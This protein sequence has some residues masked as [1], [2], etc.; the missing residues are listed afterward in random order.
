M[1]K[2]NTDDLVVPVSVAHTLVAIFF[3]DSNKKD[4]NVDEIHAALFIAD[5]LKHRAEVSEDG[6]VRISDE[7]AVTI[8]RELYARLSDPY[9]LKKITDMLTTRG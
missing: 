2:N 5:R 8:L 9:K 7:E 6:F 4:R 3:A 1:A